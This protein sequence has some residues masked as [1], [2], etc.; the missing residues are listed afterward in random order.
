MAGIGL[1]IKIKNIMKDGKTALTVGG[2]IFLIQILFSS[3]MI[4]LFF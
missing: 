2:L 1:K 3:A 4:L